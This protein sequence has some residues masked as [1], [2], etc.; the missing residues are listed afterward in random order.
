MNTAIDLDVRPITVVGRVRDYYRVK[1][2]PDVNCWPEESA[3]YAVLHNPGRATNVQS[4][5]GMANFIENCGDA[6]SRRAHALEIHEALRLM[7][8]AYRL[9]IECTYDVPLRERPRT[10]RL[11]AERSGMSTGAYGKVM[12]AALAWLQGRLCIP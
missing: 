10:V 12:A 9:V 11:A 1:Q 5:G 4:D 7:P 8:I 2:L 6:L 3:M